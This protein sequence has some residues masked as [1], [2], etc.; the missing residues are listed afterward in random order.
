MVARSFP[1]YRLAYGF[2]WERQ[3]QALGM[4]QDQASRMRQELLR[5]PACEARSLAPSAPMRWQ[6]LASLRKVQDQVARLVP[7]PLAL[8]R[9]AVFLAG[10]PLWI[11]LRH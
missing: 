5:V 11:Y 9:E 4:G 2:G 10:R 8:L 1:S 3:Q 6:L 7:S